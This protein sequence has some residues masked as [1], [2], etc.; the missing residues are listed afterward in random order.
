MHHNAFHAAAGS[1][2]ERVIITPQAECGFNSAKWFPYFSSYS[3]LGWLGKG[4]QTKLQKYDFQLT[5]VAGLGPAL[6]SHDAQTWGSFA[7]IE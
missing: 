5:P 2:K 4:A 7:G 1:R 3:A 6:M